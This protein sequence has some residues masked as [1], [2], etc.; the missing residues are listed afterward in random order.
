MTPAPRLSRRVAVLVLVLATSGVALAQAPEPIER[1]LTVGVIEDNCEGI[2]TGAPCWDASV[3][4][5]QPGDTV[6]LV[7]DLRWSQNLHNIH[8]TEGVDEAPKTDLAPAALHEVT[9]TMPASGEVT[10][11][12]DAHPTMT[13]R[14]LAPAAAAAAGG[15]A[16]HGVPG[17]GVNF[18]AYWVGLI[19][20]ALLFIVYGLTFFLFKYNETPTTTDQWDRSSEAPEGARRFSAGTASLL[21]LVFA[22]VVIAAVIYL[23]RSA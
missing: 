1:T 3:L 16:D 4:V 19:A 8:V 13:A 23:A 12:C 20:F 10:F 11:V 6:K 9:F 21:A 15:G 17:L 7:A 18:L 14:V 5:A 2:A 22:A